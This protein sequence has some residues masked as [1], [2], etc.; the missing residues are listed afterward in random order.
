MLEA[1]KTNLRRV[2]YLVLD[3]ADR[4][5]DMGFEPQIRKIVGQIRP[6]RQTC[7]WSATWPK[8]IRQLASDFQHNFIQVTIGSAEL[9]ANHRITQVV[10]VC[11]DFEKRDRMLKHMEHIMED[12]NNKV[13]IFTGTKRVADEITRFLRQDGWP[14]LSIHGDKQQ[15]ER[16]W[17][18]N[19]FK[20]GKSPI[21]VATDVASR[22]IDVKDIT[23]VFNYDYPNNSEDYVHRIGRTARAGRTGTAIT[24]FTTDN[25]KQARDLVNVLREAKQQIDPRLAEMVRYGGGGGGGRGF[26]G[27]RGG[28]GGRGGWTGSNN[29]PL[30]GGRR[31]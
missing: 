6:D 18:L 10:E 26:G 5:L 9:S 28:R 25:S 31:W 14:A 27:G 15:N 12:K 8:E 4:M 7:M 1:G 24:L 23:H 21:M 11:S 22:G 19:E 29:A 3:E 17:V 20:T 30:G 16:D 13:L 2:T